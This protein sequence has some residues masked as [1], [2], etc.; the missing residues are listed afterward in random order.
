[1]DVL[2]LMKS[3]HF[4]CLESQNIELLAGLFEF[5]RDYLYEEVLALSPRKSKA[6][7]NLDQLFANGS[8]DA[9]NAPDYILTIEK[10]LFP[11]VRSLV[12][13]Y[14]REEFSELYY[15]INQ[16]DEHGYALAS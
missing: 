16:I 12:S 4:K 6:L 9:T 7:N 11:L 1:M 13:S 14:C 3:E 15:D 5:H 8:P 10:L 2:Q